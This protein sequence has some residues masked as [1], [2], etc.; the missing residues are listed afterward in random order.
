MPE[1]LPSWTEIFAKANLSTDDHDIKFVYICS[2]EAKHYGDESE[3]G[4]YSRYGAALRMNMV[5]GEWKHF[6]LK[7]NI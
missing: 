2:I 4:K 3:H 5:K 1:Q 7:K 6:S